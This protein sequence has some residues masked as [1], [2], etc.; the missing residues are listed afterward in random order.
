MSSE[1]WIFIRGLT[2]G[3]GHWGDFLPRFQ[4]RFP[5]ADVECLDLPGNGE[6]FSETSFLSTAALAVDLRSRSRHVAA[7][8]PV[9]ML[10]H[11][12]GGMVAIQWMAQSPSDIAK[13]YLLNTSSRELTLPWRRFN[14][15]QLPT[16]LRGFTAPTALEQERRILSVIAN[17]EKRVQEVLPILAAYT[18]THPVK[19]SNALRQLT[20]AATSVLPPRTLV[21][22]EI[23]ACQKDRLVFPENSIRLA[24]HWSLRPRLHPWGGHDL[25]VDDPEWLIEQLSS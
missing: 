24:A 4:A 7:G 12:L 3:Q 15:T 25:G 23:L 22:T 16:L 18:E 1:A 10:G 6:R 21:P 14:V 8:R 5:Q 13:L 9:R 11:S 19:W 2:R 17:N 20:S